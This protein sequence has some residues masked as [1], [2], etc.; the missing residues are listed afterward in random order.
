M[1]PRLIS[2]EYE[3]VASWLRS[4]V[5]PWRRMTIVVDGVDHSGK[6]S[7]ARFLAWQLGM[8]AI[9]A[10]VA[11]KRGTGPP[12]H[13]TDLLGRLVNDRLGDNRPV[14]VEG[15]FILRSLHALGLAPDIVLGVRAKGRTGSLT[16]QR[17]FTKYRDEFP[18]SESPDYV[19]KWVPQE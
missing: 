1:E 9:E 4:R 19:F 12:A 16:W 5:L 6:S 7:L 13:D 2:P 15:V 8:P 17:A 3:A 10:D 18:R 11:L 14:I